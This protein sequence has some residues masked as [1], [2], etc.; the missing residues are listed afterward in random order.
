MTDDDLRLM[1]IFTEQVEL[2]LDTAG[3]GRRGEAAH[4]PGADPRTAWL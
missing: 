2:A 4:R 1:R 3:A